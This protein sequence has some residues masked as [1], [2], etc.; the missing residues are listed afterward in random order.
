[1]N[2][3]MSKGWHQK[4]D[5]IEKI[6]S[7]SINRNYDDVLTY[8]SRRKMAE[9]ARNKVWTK[10][11]SQKMRLHR[12]GKKHTKEEIKKIRAHAIYGEKNNM[13]K[14]FP[15][16]Y[17]MHAWVTRHKGKASYCI[18]KA[19]S[20]CKGRFEWSNVDHKYK[21]NL[22]DYSPRCTRHHRAYDIQHG[23]T[24]PEGKAANFFANGNP[25]PNEILGKEKKKST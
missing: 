17:A 1:M 24:K 10:E 3:S 11:A 2:I 16:Y 7:A 20:S 14:N 18:D 21:R 22:D 13:Y 23:L 8:E 12:L 25:K 9:T 6:R 4:P 5:A 15:T 19:F